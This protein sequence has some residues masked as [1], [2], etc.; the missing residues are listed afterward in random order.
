VAYESILFYDEHIEDDSYNFEIIEEFFLNPSRKP[1][2]IAKE[3]TIKNQV[4]GG[5][6]GEEVN[7][8]SR[9]DTEDSNSSDSSI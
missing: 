7:N 9:I 1:I 5:P 4:A 2:K 8:F 3:G 6:R